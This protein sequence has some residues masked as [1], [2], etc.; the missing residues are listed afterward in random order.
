MI[1]LY[2]KLRNALTKSK[3]HQPTAQAQEEESWLEIHFSFNLQL[4]G[5]TTD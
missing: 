5:K 2:S 3:A 4:G 1:E